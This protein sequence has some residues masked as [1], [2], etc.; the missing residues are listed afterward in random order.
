M[1]RLWDKIFGALVRDEGE[2]ANYWDID[3][4]KWSEDTCAVDEEDHIKDRQESPFL[5]HSM[6]EDTPLSS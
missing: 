6:I 3:G 5:R 1:L 2:T 4:V